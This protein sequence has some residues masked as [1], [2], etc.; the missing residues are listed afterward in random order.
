MTSIWCLCS[1]Y[2]L[3]STE[4]LATS[5]GGSMGVSLK[6]DFSFI[7]I[8]H[9]VFEKIEK[10]MQDWCPLIWFL[11]EILDPDSYIFYSDTFCRLLT[12]LKM[13]VTNQTINVCL[14]RLRIWIRPADEMITKCAIGFEKMFKT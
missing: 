12:R 11:R 7:G 6:T 1:L 13:V 8:Y 3:I 9:K 10:Y 5:S 2:T 14:S 4:T